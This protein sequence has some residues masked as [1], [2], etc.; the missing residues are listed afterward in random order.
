MT[1]VEFRKL[2]FWVDYDRP[3][4]SR[5]T[6]AQRIEYFQRRAQM[7]VLRPLRCLLCGVDPTSTWTSAVLCFG[8]CACCAIEAFGRF[9]L[10]LVG[11][12]HGYGRKAFDAF[13][14]DFMSASF[15]RQ[16]D[17]KKYVDLLR[18]HF[19]NGLAHGLAIKWGGFEESKRY[20]RSR[21]SASGSQ[22]LI[23]PRRFQDD[24]EEAFAKFVK[25]LKLAPGASTCRTRF[26]RAFD[27]LWVKGR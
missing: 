19:R 4:L 5:L 15:A 12:D 21:K 22:L 10:G 20:L 25:K 9:H 7:V 26:N 1:T 3:N 24:L 23:D 16:L 8:T 6:D 13:V 2:T 27:E 14:R 18:D 17:N 11:S